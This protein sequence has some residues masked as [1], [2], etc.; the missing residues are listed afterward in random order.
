MAEYIGRAKAIELI[1]RYDKDTAI[2]EIKRLPAADVRP[3]RH[4]RWIICSDGYYPY[5]SECTREPQGKEMTDYCPNCGAKMDGEDG[6]CSTRK[7]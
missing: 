2:R 7:W 3:E 4:G 5:C 1:E 6:F